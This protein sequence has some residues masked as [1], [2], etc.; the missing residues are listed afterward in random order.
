MLPDV[1]TLKKRHL[2][3]SFSFRDELIADSDNLGQPLHCVCLGICTLFARR[4]QP[5]WWTSAIVSCTLGRVDRK[6]EDGVLYGVCF[7]ENLGQVLIVCSTNQRDVFS[8]FLFNG[9]FLYCISRLLFL[10]VF[11]SSRPQDAAGMCAPK[12]AITPYMK[13][14]PVR[15]QCSNG[16]SEDAGRGSMRKMKVPIGD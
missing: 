11:T 8:S 12:K 2:V 13:L 4:R 7:D 5:S 3:D 14:H 1:S 15:V 9:L 10:E 6:A 16:Y